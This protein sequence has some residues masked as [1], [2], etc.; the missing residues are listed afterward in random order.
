MREMRSSPGPLLLTVKPAPL[1]ESLA[2]AALR[3]GLVT[4]SG[5][6]VLD[7]T[8][9][10]ILALRVGHKVGHRHFTPRA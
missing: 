5:L 3:G 8:E 10:A 7:A 9:A 2:R 4:S 1:V 6:E